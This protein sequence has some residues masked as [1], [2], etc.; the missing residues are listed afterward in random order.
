MAADSLVFTQAYS[1]APVCA[2]ARST[3][4]NGV[5][6][7]TQSTQHMRSRYKIPKIFKSYVVYLREQGYFCT[8]NSKT[9][10]N[11]EGDDRKI[12]DE[13]SG[14]ADY[15]HRAPG[16]SFFAIRLPLTVLWVSV[17]APVVK[18]PPPSA[19]SPAVRHEQD[20]LLARTPAALSTSKN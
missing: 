2:V 10:Y 14:T 16:Q 15:N 20:S 3:I 17:T 4:L 19:K 9:D 1:N 5:Y 18:I 7:I 13:C 12:W 8:N 11:F 6:A